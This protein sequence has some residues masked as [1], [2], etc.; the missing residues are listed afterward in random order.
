MEY[1]ILSSNDDLRAVMA[2]LNLRQMSLSVAAK[3]DG[4]NL[5]RFLRHGRNLSGQELARIQN[6]INA[7]LFVERYAFSDTF[8]FAIPIDWN[9]LFQTKG[10]DSIKLMTA[11][12]TVA[13]LSRSAAE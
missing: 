5:N 12:R 11:H 1:P 4:G 6:V 7:C 9:R 13:C 8:Q 3:V 10:F 2:R